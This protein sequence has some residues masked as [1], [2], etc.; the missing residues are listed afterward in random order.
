MDNG[1]LKLFKILYSGEIQEQSIKNG[2]ILDHFSNYGILSFYIRNNK[3][4]YTWVGEHASRALKNYIAN[5]R[6]TFSEEYPYL[7][8]LRYFTEDSLKN[9]N[10]NND[11]FS[12]IGISKQQIVNH[13]KS[14]KS[15]YETKF[16]KKLDTLKEKADTY[17]EAQKFEK[18]IET[19]NEIL[20]LARKIEDEQ[21]IKD[22]KA[23]IAEAEARIK[24]KSILNDIREEKK[25][26]KENFYKARHSDKELSEVYEHVQEFKKKYEQHFNLPALKTVRILIEKVENAWTEYSSNKVRENQ[27][28]N[29]IENVN[30]LRQNAEYSL[31]RG[32][33]RDAQNYFKKITDLINTFIEIGSRDK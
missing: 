23:F 5:I 32:L 27:L 7:R 19:S 31:N 17:F 10:E 2:D 16:A 29:V 20:E 26:I 3:R 11:F 12:D 24:I 25:I 33:L 6:H 21:L 18:A 22:Q 30:D 15:K 1:N 13:L 9:M 8:V 4:L 28:N 14:E